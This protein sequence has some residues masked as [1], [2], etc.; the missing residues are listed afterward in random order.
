MAV[1]KFQLLPHTPDQI[2]KGYRMDAVGQQVEAE[3]ND[4][5]PYR[6]RFHKISKIV[7]LLGPGAIQKEP[8]RESLGVAQKLVHGF[9]LSKYSKALDEEKHSILRELV[10]NEFSWFEQ[11]FDDAGFVTQARAKLTWAA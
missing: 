1:W 5:L 3:V 2:A 8:Y 11:N 10:T 4:A 6:F 7:L 9:D